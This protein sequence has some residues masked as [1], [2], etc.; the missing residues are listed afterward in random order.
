MKSAPTPVLV[1]SLMLFCVSLAL[2]AVASYPGYGALFVG[3]FAVLFLDPWGL[4]W[5]ANPA[6]LVAAGLLASRHPV[7]ASVVGGAA[8]GLASIALG[9][10]EIMV[11]EGGS[12]RPATRGAGYFVWMS[13]MM[14]LVA[15]ALWRVWKERES[16]RS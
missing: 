14:V 9:L 12:T 13:A 6:Y 7:A 1:V 8:L 10:G 16:S 4:V 5:L 15:G 11:D 2:P 3:P